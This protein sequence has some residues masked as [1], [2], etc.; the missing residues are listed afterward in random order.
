[1]RLYDGKEWD[2]LSSRQAYKKGWLS[3][4]DCEANERFENEKKLFIKIV[5]MNRRY[6][7]VIRAPFKF[8]QVIE[9]FN[10]LL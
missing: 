8:Y 6:V 1:M 4:S 9:K 3:L 2:V 10:S 7:G 5:Y